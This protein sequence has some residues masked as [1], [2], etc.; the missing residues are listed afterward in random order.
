MPRWLFILAI[1]LVTWLALNAH[2]RGATTRAWNTMSQAELPEWETP[3]NHPASDRPEDAF[4]RA[5]NKS[6]KRVRDA[7]GPE[8][9][10]E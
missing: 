3:A 10:G 2:E 8:A 6:K 1:A 5:W 4:Q 7:L 9:I